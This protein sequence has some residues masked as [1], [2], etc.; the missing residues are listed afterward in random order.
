MELLVAIGIFVLLL[1]VFI[2]YLSA[3]RETAHRTECENRLG[4]IGN[5]LR[6]YA[7]ANHQQ[8]PRVRYDET[9][10]PNGY[11]S[12]TGA[13]DDDPFAAN[14]AVQPND[15]TA[16]PWLLVREGYLTNTKVFVCP[17]TSDDPDLMEGDAHKTVDKLA[18][19]NFS[20]ARNLSYSYADP[21]TNAWNFRFDSDHLPAEYALMAD[22]NP[23]FGVPPATGSAGAPPGASWPTQP[24]SPA[25]AIAVPGPARNAPPF[26]LALGNSRNHG[27]AGQNVLFAAGDVTFETTP[28]CG[29]ANDNIYTA[30]APS[31]LEKTDGPVALDRPGFWGRG[32]GPAYDDDSVLAPSDGEGPK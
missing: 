29:V 5:A 25:G 28:Y 19:G 13:Q 32:V 22:R 20:L 18:R 30:V 24:A 14:S 15:V 27:R 10:N 4:E 3:V 9:H 26:Q 11:V 6:Q 21:F 23:G 17:S 12:F 16:C 2:P 31:R 1:A 7:A 8:Y